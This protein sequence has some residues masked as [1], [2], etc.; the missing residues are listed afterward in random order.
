MPRLYD[1]TVPVIA[2]PDQTVEIHWQCP[3]GT[4]IVSVTCPPKSTRDAKRDA[5][6]K[7]T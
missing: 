2:R 6:K 7:R 4:Y 5:A 1:K 3:D